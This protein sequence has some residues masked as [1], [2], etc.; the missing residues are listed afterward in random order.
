MS[1]WKLCQDCTRWHGATVPCLTLAEK[2]EALTFSAWRR[3]K[4]MRAELFLDTRV[5]DYVLTHY[6]PIEWIITFV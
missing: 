2:A 1:K 6:S 4:G 3:K 5:S